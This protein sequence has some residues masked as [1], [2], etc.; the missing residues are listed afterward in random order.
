MNSLPP[1]QRTMV[2]PDEYGSKI[3]PIPGM[4]VC[5]FCTATPIVAR[6]PCTTVLMV[7]T[8]AGTHVSSDPWAACAECLKL[9]A[10][11]DRDGLLERALHN[12]AQSE[13]PLPAELIAELRPMFAETQRRFF[14]GRI[15][16]AQPL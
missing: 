9:V 3:E 1:D 13:G 11:N 10:A 14:A 7:E 5:D 8:P 6:F 4:A 15:G 16:D 2:T 12:L